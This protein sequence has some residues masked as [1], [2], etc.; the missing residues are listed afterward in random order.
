[1]SRSFFALGLV[2]ALT[3]L[4]GCSTH[5]HVVTIAPVTVSDITGR[6]T[7]TP[8]PPQ[9]GDDLIT[10]T[11][12]DSNGNPVNNATISAMA[13]T[14]LTGNTGPIVSGRSDGN[15]IYRLPFTLPLTEL[16]IVTITVQRTA[17]PDVVMK[18]GVE[19]Q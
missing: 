6:F 8:N 13:T 10:A 7:L 18:I 19:P 3:L 14:T 17:K 12:I 9:A 2:V 1:M 11:L 16:Y 15:G 5:K 4:S